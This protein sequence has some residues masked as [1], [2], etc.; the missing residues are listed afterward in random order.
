MYV[1]LHVYLLLHQMTHNKNQIDVNILILQKKEVWF[2]G[3]ISAQ[4]HKVAEPE[5]ELTLPNSK[6]RVF[7][8]MEEWK[9]SNKLK[10]HRMS[11]MGPAKIR[12]HVLIIAQ[13]S[14]Q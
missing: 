12:N 14:S 11:M 7:S 9:E 1:L 2:G 5:C 3:L 8:F 10:D 4:T 13:K 6:H